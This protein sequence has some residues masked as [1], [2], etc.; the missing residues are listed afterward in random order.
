MGPGGRAFLVSLLA[1][2]VLGV[3]LASWHVDEDEAAPQEAVGEGGG[4]NA[5]AA[6]GTRGN[7]TRGNGTALEGNASAG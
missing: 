7:E 1:F 3:A 2:V 4:G 6:N 5:T